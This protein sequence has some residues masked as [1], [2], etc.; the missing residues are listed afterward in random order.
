MKGWLFCLP[1]MVMVAG[2]GLRAG[3][4]VCQVSPV[5]LSVSVWPSMPADSRVG[6]EV[7]SSLAGLPGLP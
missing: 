2:P 4:C 6:V 5:L 7:V 1:V 3:A